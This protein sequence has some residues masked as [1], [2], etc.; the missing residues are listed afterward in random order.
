M[1]I[2][3]PVLG[4]GAL[5]GFVTAGIVVI[6]RFSPSPHRL[7]GEERRR[8][9]DL[10]ARV[11]ELEELKHR[12]VELEERVDFSERLLTKPAERREPGS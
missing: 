7:E 5:I 11:G 2:V 9:E 4:I 10:Q 6:R 3:G 12:M 8:L 1:E